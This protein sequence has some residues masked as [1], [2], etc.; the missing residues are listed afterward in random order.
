M[1]KSTF[2]LL[3]VKGE[4]VGKDYIQIRSSD[5]LLLSNSRCKPPYDRLSKIFS[6]NLTEESIQRIIDKLEFGKLT[7]LE[8]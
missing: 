1:L 6:K 8:L 4:I 3:N 2:Y 7:K 5:M